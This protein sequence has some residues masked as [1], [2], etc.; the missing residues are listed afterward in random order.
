MNIT[1][2]QQPNISR[3]RLIHS[4]YRIP[5]G[6]TSAFGTPD[7]TFAF[8][9]TFSPRHVDANARYNRNNDRNKKHAQPR[10]RNYARPGRSD[11]IRDDRRAT[12]PHA[13]HIDIPSSLGI[14]RTKET[15]ETRNDAMRDERDIKNAITRRMFLV[16]RIYRAFAKNYIVRDNNAFLDTR[17][18]VSHRHTHDTIISND[19]RHRR[20]RLL[21]A[22]DAEL[23][24]IASCRFRAFPASRVPPSFSARSASLGD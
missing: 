12:L 9:R 14:A 15:R 11:E 16:S 13:C 3:V 10:S 20:S 8:V 24:E 19:E 2:P 7:A 18:R 23:P 4:I 1:T 6:V 21:S 22:L 5:G 17:Y